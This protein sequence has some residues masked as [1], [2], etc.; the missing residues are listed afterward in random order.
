[1]IQRCWMVL[2]GLSLGA[3]AEPWPMW[4]G[5]AGS[6][7]SNEKTLPLRWSAKENITWKV[8]LPDRGNSTPIV[9]GDRIFLTQPLEKTSERALLCLDRRDGRVLW[10]RAVKYAA[11]EESHEDNPFCSESPATDGERVVAVFGSAGVYCYDMEGRL[12]WNRDLGKIQFTWGAAS[13]PVIHGGAVFIYRGP[14]PKAHLLALDKATGK[15]LW[16]QDDPEVAVEGRTD[17][18]RGNRS[19][20]WICSY[21][22]P[23]IAG[24]GE[25]EVLVMSHPGELRALDPAT[26]KV[27]WNC[28]GLNP[29]VYASPIAGED[30]VVAM[31]GFYGTTLAVRLGGKGDV[32]GTHKLWQTIRTQNRLGSGVVHDGHLYVLNTPGFVECVELKTGRVFF[33]ERLRGAGAKNESWSSMLLAQDRIYVPNESGETYVLRA[34][35]KFELLSSNPLDGALTHASLAAADGQLFVR[36]HRHLWCIGPRTPA[37]N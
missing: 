16:R 1:M 22:T 30:I 3:H 31:G 34:S 20:E 29:L 14:D 13:S 11:A 28:G 26:G 6:G 25:Q 9:W 5:A 15:T 27:R 24:K 18:F 7:V 21:S 4:R 36:T 10:Q 8:A 23:L 35:P 33:N 12:L 32:S 17:G 2:L 19:R 37:V